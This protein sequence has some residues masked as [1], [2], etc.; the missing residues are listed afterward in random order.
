[1]K[2]K[3]KYTEKVRTI[4]DKIDFLKELQGNEEFV[5]VLGLVYKAVTLF[6]II[7]LV[8]MN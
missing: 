5:Q 7:T 3:N 8:K 4:E 2:L 1:M 6:L